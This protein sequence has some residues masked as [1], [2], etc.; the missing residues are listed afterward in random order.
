[1]K[2]FWSNFNNNKLKLLKIPLAKLRKEVEKLST[3]LKTNP[4]ILPKAQIKNL[5][6]R[7]RL[8]IR[9]KEMVSKSC[10]VIKYVKLNTDLKNL[11]LL[12]FF[13]L[14]EEMKMEAP[15]EPTNSEF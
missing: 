6:R 1:M 15:S 3:L 13:M 8:V 10:Y 2:A 11:N 9:N 12:I 5:D 7:F 14:V 4:I